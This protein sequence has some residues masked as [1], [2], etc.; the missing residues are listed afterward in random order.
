M[1]AAACNRCGAVASGCGRIRAANLPAHRIVRRAE[2]DQVGRL[3]CQKRQADACP[4]R[5]RLPPVSLCSSLPPQI[6]FKPLTPFTTSKTSLLGGCEVHRKC[7]HRSPATGTPPYVSLKTTRLRASPA[8]H[9]DCMIEQK[10]AG[11]TPSSSIAIGR[12]PRIAIAEYWTGRMTP[13]RSC[14]RSAFGLIVNFARS[15][16]PQMPIPQPHRER[17]CARC[18]ETRAAAW[19]WRLPLSFPERST[20]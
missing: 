2:A 9:S 8:F 19:D 12:A 15:E 6:R 4:A 20:R 5:P 18:R 14:V 11:S 17:R 16:R 3:Q 13:T 10:S 7:R 1:D